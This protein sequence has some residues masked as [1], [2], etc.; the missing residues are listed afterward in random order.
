MIPVNQ[1]IVDSVRGDCQRA[2]VASILGFEMD[3]VPHFRL[4][5]HPTWWH[6]FYY[7]LLACGWEYMGQHFPERS[8]LQLEDSIDG[9]FMACVPS[10]TYP[11]EMGITHAVLID[12]QGLVVHDP[13]PNKLYQGENVLESGA[14]KYWYCFKPVENKNV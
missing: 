4:F 2:V 1:N 7:F 8:T 13:H 12:M 11:A 10:R 14:L 5:A 6:V 3:Q 9:H